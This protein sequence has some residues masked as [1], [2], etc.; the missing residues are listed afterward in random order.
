MNFKNIVIYIF[1]FSLSYISA[2]QNKK[3]LFTVE[4][5]PVYSDEFMK[6]FNKNREIVADE[7]KKTIE[8]YLELYINYKLKLKQ[9]YDLK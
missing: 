4:D 2:Q 7:N 5:K 1:F 8:E 3:A 9:A 6:V